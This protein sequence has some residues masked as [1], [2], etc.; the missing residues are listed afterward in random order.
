[1]RI[2]KFF[3]SVIVVSI[4]WFILPTIIYDL[5]IKFGGLVPP[6]EFTSVKLAILIPIAFL[7]GF[8]FVLLFFLSEGSKIARNG[9]IYGFLWW[10]GSGIVAEVGFWIVLDLPVVMMIAG[11]TANL[12]LLLNGI[13]VEK[14]N[15][16]PTAGK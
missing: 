10:L 15:K 11:I 13:I 6:G 7:H 14:L 5:F 8:A 12:T 3:I 1:M 16:I 4:I 2:K 9:L